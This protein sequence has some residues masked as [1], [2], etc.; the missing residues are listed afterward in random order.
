M[1]GNPAQLALLKEIE[2]DKALNEFYYDVAS[3]RARKLEEES[4]TIKQSLSQLE[5]NY[6]ELEDD[7][8]F[9]KWSILILL[10]ALIL[11]ILVRLRFK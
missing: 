4:K 7:V 1:Y 2:L 10:P 9:I 6:T 3:L 11:S 5:V 8:K